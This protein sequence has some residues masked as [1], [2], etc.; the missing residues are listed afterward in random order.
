MNQ[1]PQKHMRPTHA[2]T[3]VELIIVITLIAILSAVGFI[4][5][6]S[7][8]VDARDASRVADLGNLKV[9]LRSEFQKK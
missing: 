5:Y 1:S 2:F 7:Y 4:S 9:Q 3:L 8:L 6:A